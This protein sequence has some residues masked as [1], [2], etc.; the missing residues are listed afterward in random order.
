LSLSPSE[1][2]LRASIAAHTMHAL[3]GPEVSAPGR[4]AFLSRFERQIR[5]GAER[6]GEQLSDAEIARR[7]EHL[8]RAY[9]KGLAFRSA[10]ARAERKAR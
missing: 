9:F 3:N 8:K 7:A 2:R 10:K 5:E 1:R 4:K 6:R